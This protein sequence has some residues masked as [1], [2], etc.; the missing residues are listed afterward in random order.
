M[1]STAQIDNRAEPANL[2]LPLD[3]L[4]FENLIDA[5]IDDAIASSAAKAAIEASDYHALGVAHRYNVLA[6]CALHAAWVDFQQAARRLCVTAQ[7]A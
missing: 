1:T 7:A 2:R 6:R 3:Q 5:S 4:W